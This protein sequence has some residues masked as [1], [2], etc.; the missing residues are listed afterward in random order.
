MRLG[1]PF[2]VSRAPSSPLSSLPPPSTPPCSPS[3]QVARVRRSSLFLSLSSLTLSRSRCPYTD[4]FLL[5][6]ARATPRVHRQWHG[7][8]HSSHLHSFNA[9]CGPWNVTRRPARPVPDLRYRLSLIRAASL[10]GFPQRRFLCVS[11]HGKLYLRSLLARPSEPPPRPESDGETWE[12]KIS[13][14][15]PRAVIDRCSTTNLTARG[16]WWRWW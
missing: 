12:R 5:S 9:T 7:P 6:F 10:A 2:S 1:F 16:W 13:R 3:H 15:S 11:S 8:P 14:V 4:F